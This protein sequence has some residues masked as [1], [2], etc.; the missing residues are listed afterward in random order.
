MLEFGECQAG[1]ALQGARG[2]KMG[3][4]RRAL[5][6]APGLGTI[7]ELVSNYIHIHIYIIYIYIVLYYIIL[8]Y[9]ILYYICI[10]VYIRVLI[11][12]RRDTCIVNGSM[13]WS[14]QP[15]KQAFTVYARS[16]QK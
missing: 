2:A 3:P 10:C 12:M 1:N 6:S 16:H 4:A 13:Q 7:L 15:C 11:H 5:G 9:T 14:V 8:Y